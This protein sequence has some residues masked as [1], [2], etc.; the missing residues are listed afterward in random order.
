MSIKEYIL[1]RKI[2]LIIIVSLLLVTIFL[3]Y[4]LTLKEE[5]KDN[6]LI[7][8][9]SFNE[10]EDRA[11]EVTTIKVDIKGAVKKP[12]VYEMDSNSRV[13]D[14]ITKAGG[15]TTKASTKYINLSKKLKDENIIIISKTTE[16]KKVEE[17]TN[18]EEITINTSTSN[19]ASIKM[20]DLITNEVVEE[21]KEEVKETT[22]TE[23]TKVV[24]INTATKEELMTLSNIGEAKAIK[25]IE[26]RT[27]NGSFKSTD[28]LKNV[29]G[30]GDK[31]YDS[32]KENITI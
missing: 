11:E 10:E 31:L 26:Y 32:I 27:T 21:V 5:V 20:E 24:N 28:E 8:D 30:I 17:K 9:N 16:L 22:T 29:S 1:T 12:G 15:L 2:E 13:I 25:I 14:A 23:T 4:K 18:I 6:S 19:D 3:G 7:V